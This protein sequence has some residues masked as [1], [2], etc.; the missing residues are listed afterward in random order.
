[1][2]TKKG[3]GKGKEAFISTPHLG[4]SFGPSQSTKDTTLKDLTDNITE[5]EIN[6]KWHRNK[7]LQNR[8]QKMKE[9]TVLVQGNV[10][11][12]EEEERV[13]AK[14]PTSIVLTVVNVSSP[15]AKIR[16]IAIHP[17]ENQEEA[18]NLVELLLFLFLLTK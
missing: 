13:L 6:L 9:H 4:R 16:G 18:E 17:D 5:S 7:T 10:H 3:K 14:Q 15:S 1:M 11:G 2:G 12:R 8:E